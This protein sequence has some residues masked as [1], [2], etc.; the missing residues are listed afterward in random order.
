MGLTTCTAQNGNARNTRQAQTGI[1][2][3]IG[4]K[5]YSRPPSCD[6]GGFANAKLQRGIRRGLCGVYRSCIVDAI[7]NWD[8]VLLLERLVLTIINDQIL[9]RDRSKP[10][11]TNDPFSL[12]SHLDGIAIS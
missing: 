1:Y 12:R 5:P 9:L 3:P 2:R 10:K 11:L 4:K 6:L 7:G 8:R